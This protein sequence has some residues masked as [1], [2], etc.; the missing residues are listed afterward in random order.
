MCE[1]DTIS[2]N[3]TIGRLQHGGGRTLEAVHGGILENL[4]TLLES[5][6]AHTANQPCGLH[7]GIADLQHALKMFS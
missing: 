6:P 7:S 1:H 2:G 5:D 3:R 4:N